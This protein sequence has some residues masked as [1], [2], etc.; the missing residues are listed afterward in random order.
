[1]AWTS[2]ESVLRLSLY[3]A[4]LVVVALVEVAVPRRRRILPRLRRWPANLGI[5]AVSTLL[6]RLV[7]PV[8]GIGMAALAAKHGWGLLNADLA[9]PAW[10]A[11]ALTV[12]LL[13]L[14]IYFQHVVFH[15]VPVLWRL[16]RMHHADLDVDATTGA[17]F[18][19]V[20]IVL[21]MVV[22]IGAVAALGAPAL[23][24]LLF[25][26]LLNASSTF[27]HA[28]LRLPEAAD[29]ALRWLIVTPDMHRV[30]HS[31]IAA[32]TNSNFGFSL[33][34]WDWL[35]GTYRAQPAAGH[36]RMTLGIEQFRDP[37]ELRLDRLLLQPLRGDD[38][39]YT[40]A[41][42]ARV[43]RDGGLGT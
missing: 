9:L 32:E 15:A 1:M 6:V 7:V 11:I 35:G 29:R 27:N 23:G 12:V 19:P 37:S 41:A 26:V 42:R 25:E 38:A 22:K 2:A 28:N 4:V 14:V 18:H 36:E 21:S 8:S 20:E 43:M 33:P 39:P 40:P 30:H 10:A 31:I 17:R 13:D 5:V 3:L 34:W 24:V 16:H